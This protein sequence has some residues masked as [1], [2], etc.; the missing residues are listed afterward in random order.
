MYYMIWLI[1]LSGELSFHGGA[2]GLMHDVFILR[3][4]CIFGLA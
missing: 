4:L 1:L 3:R 2:C